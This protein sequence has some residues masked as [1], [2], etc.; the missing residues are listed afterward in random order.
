[1]IKLKLNKL[2][3]IMNKS[4]LNFRNSKTK[5]CHSEKLYKT[6]LTPPK[7]TNKLFKTPSKQSKLKYKKD[8]TSKKATFFNKS[9]H[10]KEDMIQ[11]I[12]NFIN[13]AKASSKSVQKCKCWNIRNLLPLYATRNT[14]V[15]IF[16]II[17]LNNILD[18]L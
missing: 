7:G 11:R 8:S 17:T 1:M 15:D 3:E 5:I 9:N 4:K 16:W 10:W 14:F 6:L 13:W 18:G 12:N 2:Q